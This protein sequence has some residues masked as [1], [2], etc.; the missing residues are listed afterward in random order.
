MRS[1]EMRLR[2]M[3]M[4]DVIRSIFT[5][6]AVL[7]LI[8]GGVWGCGETESSTA[9]GGVNKG[10]V[11]D[12]LS[13]KRQLAGGTVLATVNGEPIYKEDVDVYLAGGMH[14]SSPGEALNNVIDVALLSD[15]AARRGFSGKPDVFA[16]YTKALAMEQLVRAGKE[17]TV[18]R[19]PEKMLKA[20]YEQQKRRFVHGTVRSVVHA[21]VLTSE[22]KKEPTAEDWQ[23]AR[24]ILDAVKNTDSAAAFRLAVEAVQTAHMNRKITIEN[25]PA[26]ERDTTRLVKPF[27]DGTWAVDYPNKHI[28]KI[29]R[30]RFGL[31]V[32][33]V[34]DEKPAEN[35]SFEEARPTLAKELLP[36]AR[37]K[38]INQYI[39]NLVA[40]GN[41]FI[42]DE[43]LSQTVSGET[44]AA[45]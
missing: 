20:A 39:D 45:K 26:F 2:E 30:T 18:D 33:F 31:H 23:L 11:Q 5:R 8:T 27:V 37:K 7:A 13:H 42:Y 34:I 22:G 4:L 43:I 24:D 44:S 41:V 10:V 6:Y 14:A 17:F 3:N 32:I 38:Y 1:R 40:A 19:V 28:S 9:S 12:L 21:L 16:A 35:L 36:A 29:V 15:E 25:I